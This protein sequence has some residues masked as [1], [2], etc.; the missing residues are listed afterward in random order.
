MAEGE[1][2]QQFSSPTYVE[3]SSGKSRLII[4]FLILFVLVIAALAGFYFFMLK[5]QQTKS[6]VTP[7][8]TPTSAV[9]PTTLPSATPSGLLSPSVSKKLTISPS[10]SVDK[11]T[12][13]DRSTITIAVLNGSGVKGAASAISTYLS[14]LGYK[15]QSTGNAEVFTYEGITVKAKK[16]NSD[17]LTL[18]KNDISKENPDVSVTAK[19]DDTI[20]TDAVVIVGK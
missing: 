19:T 1:S 18:L 14:G 13:L 12:K 7:T 6:T 17:Y 20:T 9:T 15:V 8:A 4:T 3:R 16:A 10:G 2:P 5:G 11:N